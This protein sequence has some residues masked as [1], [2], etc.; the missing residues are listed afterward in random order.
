MNLRFTIYDL[1]RKAGAPGTVPARYVG[2][3]GPAKTAL[4]VPIYGHW[5]S[6]IANIPE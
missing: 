3:S 6:A 5:Q 1:R 2:H 4:G